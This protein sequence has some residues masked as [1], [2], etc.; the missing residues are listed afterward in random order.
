VQ[1]CYDAAPSSE[2]DFLRL[3]GLFFSVSSSSCRQDVTSIWVWSLTGYSVGWATVCV[4]CL[5]VDLVLLCVLNQL[6][7]VVFIIFVFNFYSLESFSLIFFFSPLY[8]SV[9]KIGWCIRMYFLQVWINFKYFL[10]NE[11][12]LRL[13]SSCHQ[14]NEV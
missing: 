10:Q 8:T 11:L 13:L 2:R 4:C 12:G 5:L 14:K 7:V 3:L 9:P 6:E 1:F